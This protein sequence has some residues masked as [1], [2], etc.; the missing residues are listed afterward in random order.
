MKGT[1]RSCTTNQPRTTTNLLDVEDPVQLAIDR[2]VV[3][4]LGY[5]PE[6]EGA[7]LM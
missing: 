7:R 1:L 6:V 2:I 3:N 5:P 4:A